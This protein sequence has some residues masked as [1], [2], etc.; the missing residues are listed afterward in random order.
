MLYLAN[1]RLKEA[2]EPGLVSIPLGQLPEGIARIQVQCSSNTEARAIAKR[3]RQEERELAQ[4]HK[5]GM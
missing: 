2:T 5:T 3:F 1:K 4:K